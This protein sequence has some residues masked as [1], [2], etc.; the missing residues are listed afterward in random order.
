MR[1]KLPYH[2]IT[3]WVQTSQ[4]LKAYAVTSSFCLPCQPCRPLT[5]QPSAIIRSAIHAPPNDA[6]T[7]NT[8]RQ[9]RVPTNVDASRTTKQPEASPPPPPATATSNHAHNA[10]PTSVPSAA[11]LTAPN[12]TVL[13]HKQPTSTTIRSAIKVQSNTAAPSSPPT[14]PSSNPSKILDLTQPNHHSSLPKI[15]IFAAEVSAI[16]GHNP[17]KSILDVFTPIWQ[18]TEPDTYSE[19]KLHYEQQ[20]GHA[21]ISVEEEARRLIE[22]HSMT[23]LMDEAISVAPTMTNSDFSNYRTIITN[24]IDSNLQSQSPDTRHLIQSHIIDSMSRE[25]GVRQEM[26]TIKTFTERTGRQVKDSNRIFYKKCLGTLPTELQYPTSSS[27]TSC[28][29]ASTSSSSA[30]EF[31]TGGRIDGL[32]EDGLPLEIKNRVSHFKNP[33]PPYDRV[34]FQTYLH[35]LDKPRGI[36]CERLTRNISST[37]NTPSS[38]T[39]NDELKQTP[40]QRDPLLWYQ[41]IQPSLYIFSAVLHV[42]LQSKDLQYKYIAAHGA[43][44]EQ[45]QILGQISQYI[46]Q[47]HPPPVLQVPQELL[48]V[49]QTPRKFFK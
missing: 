44:E 3:Q 6:A 14:T 15:M 45:S 25:K 7:N 43:V 9:P 26:L 2:R 42:M 32:T 48:N 33:L 27:T 34:Q 46:T 23:Q 5:L 35:L 36:L 21:I 18:R 22:Q 40:I 38:T 24:Y 13:N 4:T 29:P 31:W 1:C 19:I 37:P 11:S 49:S 8:V 30:R 10:P 20:S 16:S 28:N 41:S 12:M 17:H 39:N 47:H